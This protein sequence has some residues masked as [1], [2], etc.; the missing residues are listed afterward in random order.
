M[1]FYIWEIHICHT[2][3]YFSNG[4]SRLVSKT[5]IYPS[6]KSISA[7]THAQIW[8]TQ[9]CVYMHAYMDFPDGEIRIFG[10]SLDSSTGEIQAVTQNTD[11]SIGEIHIC[12]TSLDFSNGEIQTGVKNL[13]F[14]IGEIHICLHTCTY[15]DNPNMCIYACIYGFL[16]WRNPYIWGQFGF[17]HWGN[18][19]SHPK[20]GFLHWVNQYV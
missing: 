8:I 15:L 7:S 13:D 9:M 14:S 11:F 6:E 3:L 5:W 10:T 18:P 12:S 20:Y 17:L 2:S 4:E 19:R 16:Q 1:D